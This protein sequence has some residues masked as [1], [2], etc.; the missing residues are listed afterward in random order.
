MLYVTVFVNS[1]PI[2]FNTFYKDL[3]H[4]P[5]KIFWDEFKL[6]SQSLFL[7]CHVVNWKVNKQKRQRDSEIYKFC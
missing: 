5:G 6:L 1:L 4:G 2:L 7:C 3:S